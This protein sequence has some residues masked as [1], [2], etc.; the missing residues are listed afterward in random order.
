M[1]ISPKVGVAPA[2]PTYTKPPPLYIGM[3]LARGA[4]SWWCCSDSDSDSCRDGGFPKLLGL[5]LDFWVNSFHA[6]PIGL[7]L[8]SPKVGVAPATPTC[9]KPPPLDS[10]LLIGSDSDSDS[11]SDVPLPSPDQTI[12]RYNRMVMNFCISTSEIAAPPLRKACIHH[13]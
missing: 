9:T 11:E 12:N 3:L 7:M 10:G 5:Q 6:T 13:W 8:I 2:T 4:E 1:L